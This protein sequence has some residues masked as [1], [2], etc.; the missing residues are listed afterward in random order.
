EG[1]LQRELRLGAEV[2]LAQSAQCAIEYAMPIARRITT[3][4]NTQIIA[5]RARAGG[6][7][8][9][10][11]GSSS[12][13]GST[14]S[15]SSPSTM[16]ESWRSS[17]SCCSLIFG[18]FPCRRGRQTSEHCR[19]HAAVRL[20]HHLA[21]EPADPGPREDRARPLDLLGRRAVDLLAHGNLR[22]VDAPLAV[23]AE[24]ARPCRA[25]AQAPCVVQHRVRAVD[26]GEAEG[27]RGDEDACE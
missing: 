13:G 4:R 19:G 21:V 10:V 7:G 27:A 3:T 22:G 12:G 17:M 15:A 2:A 5:C 11:N 1:H 14:W 9:G 23:V 26:R 16:S 24:R 6:D 25:R 18:S 20:V 8:S